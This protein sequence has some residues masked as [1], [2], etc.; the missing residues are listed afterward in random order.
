M[1]LTV[2]VVNHN[3]CKLLK[4][5]IN[6]LINACL[7]YD[8]EVVVVDNAS[9]DG[10]V[11]MVRRHFPEQQLIA[12]DRNVGIAAAFNQAI[13]LTRSE[14]V[15]LVTPDI[16]AGSDALS[17]AVDFMDEHPKAGGVSLRVVD[18]LGNFITHSKYGLN[19][20][21]IKMIRLFK[22]ERYFPKS[23]VITQKFDFT[24]EFETAEVD[25]LNHTGMMLRRTA[26]DKVGGF[27]NRFVMFG[28]DVDI[29]FQLKLA[30][31]KN[32]YFHRSYI[33]SHEVAP[34]KHR[35]FSYYRHFYGSML[36]FVI[37]YLLHIP[38]LSFKALK[39]AVAL[40][41]RLKQS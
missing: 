29:S 4:E 6:S 13:A 40:Q 34:I 15:F 32:Y 28:Y 14:Y 3:M 1:K 39:Q 21:W 33:I 26:F 31:Y 7:A 25:V 9:T 24:D 10:S 27:D 23:H 36:T 41:L 16:I 38:N 17:K 12:N 35:T 11:E 5:C 2:V 30:G 18:P 8:C 19:S 20:A 37:K 22:L